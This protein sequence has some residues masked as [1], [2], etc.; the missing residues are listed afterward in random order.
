TTVVEK[1]A[2]PAPATT[3]TAS[4]RAAP[5][6]ARKKVVA[7]KPVTVADS[8]GSDYLGPTIWRTTMDGGD[9]SIAEQDGQLQLIVGPAAVPGGTYDQIDVHVGTQCSFPD[10]FDARV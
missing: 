7:S 3:T 8:F 6:A 1:T 2:R 4:T 10:D 9:V 5:R